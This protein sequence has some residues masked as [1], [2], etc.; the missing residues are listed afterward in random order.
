VEKIKALEKIQA[1]EKGLYYLKKKVKSIG[2]KKIKILF[3]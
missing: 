3:S 1:L 2:G